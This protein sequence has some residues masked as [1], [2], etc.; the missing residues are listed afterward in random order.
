ML[1]HCQRKEARAQPLADEM[2]VLP[3]AIGLARLVGRELS[4][5][6]EAVERA[7]LLLQG[8][9]VGWI[10]LA[11]RVLV[12]AADKVKHLLFAGLVGLDWRADR[13]QGC[14]V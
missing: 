3:H 2:K 11:A 9:A 5:E 8:V 10:A 13:A 12:Q 6:I 14:A 7:K 4:E 1:F